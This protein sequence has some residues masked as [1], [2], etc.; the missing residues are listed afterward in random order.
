MSKK[1]FVWRALA[2]LIIVGLVVA[3]G[4]GAYYAGWS[5]GYAT[6]QLATGSE[7]G[8]AMPYAPHGPR[9]PGRP[10]GFA[11]FMFGAG[12]LL[13]IVLLIVLLVVVGKLIR[14]AAW[15]IVG[16][17][18]MAGPW[19]RHW[20]HPHWH[21]PHGPVPPWFREWQEWPEGSQ[22]DAQADETA[23]EQ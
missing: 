15:A 8:E 5:R 20:H 23:A 14:F 12:P 3:A 17:P 19:A 10:F 21:R 16:G 22:A 18:A 11:P 9:Y 2:A 7:A 4:A 6:G 13:R 1:Q